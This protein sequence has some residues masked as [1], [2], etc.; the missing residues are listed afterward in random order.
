VTNQDSYDPSIARNYDAEYAVIRDP[1]GDRSFYAELAREAAGPALELGCGTGRVLLPIAREGLPCVGLDLSRNMLDMLRAKNPPANLELVQAAMTDFDFGARRFGLVF[2]AFRVVQHLCAV[3]EQL[4]AL[5]C[6]R[7][8][9]APQGRFVFD[10][11]APNLARTALEDEP[12]FEDVRARD[13]DAEIRR[14]VRVHR[15][16]VAQ[17]MTLHMRHE[18]WEERRRSARASRTSSCAGFI[19]TRSSTS[20]RAPAS[21]SRLSTEDSTGARTTRRAT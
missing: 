14:F 15:D 17:L 19:A 11:F 7:R 6:V 16:H 13:G 5:A 18:R 12:E 21:W 8:H 10:V 4:A 9:L 20:W 1:S 2:A 3:E